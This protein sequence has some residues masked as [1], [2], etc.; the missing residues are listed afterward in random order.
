M[1]VEL[2]LAPSRAS[3][4]STSP[5][6]PGQVRPEVCGRFMLIEIRSQIYSSLSHPE[7][8]KQDCYRRY[9]LSRSDQIDYRRGLLPPR[10]SLA[11]PLVP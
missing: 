7:R 10:V 1:D 6:Q 3:G 2:I 5:R 9:D 4:R 11:H 8:S